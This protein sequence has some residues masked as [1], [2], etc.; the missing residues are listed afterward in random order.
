M[1]RFSMVIKSAE[2]KLRNVEINEVTVR[3]WVDQ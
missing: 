3:K 2:E 1:F